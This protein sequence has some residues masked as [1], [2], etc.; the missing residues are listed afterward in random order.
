MFELGQMILGFPLM[1]PRLDLS[2]TQMASKDRGGI[3]GCPRSRASAARGEEK[4]R[5]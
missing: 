3:V 2:L 5:P 1:E 4:A